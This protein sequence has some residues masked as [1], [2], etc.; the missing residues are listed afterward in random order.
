MAAQEAPW[1]VTDR[2]VRKLRKL[3][4]KGCALSKGAAK[5]SIDQH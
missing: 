1:M 4:S 5:A 2:Q 3:M